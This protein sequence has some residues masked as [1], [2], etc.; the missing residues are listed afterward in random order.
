MGLKHWVNYGQESMLQ[1]GLRVAKNAISMS[2]TIFAWHNLEMSLGWLLGL[3]DIMSIKVK[4]NWLLIDVVNRIFWSKLTSIKAKE[5]HFFIEKHLN[6]DILQNL[7]W[8]IYVISAY[9]FHSSESLFWSLTFTYKR[10]FCA[11]ILDSWID[12]FLHF[13]ISELST[14]FY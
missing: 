2:L 13:S 10:W 12:N 14:V 8:L 5:L 1:R 9:F 7:C 3:I 6:W 11:I 4:L